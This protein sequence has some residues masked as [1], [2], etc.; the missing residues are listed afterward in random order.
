MKNKKLFYGIIFLVLILILVYGAKQ[1]SNEQNSEEIYSL[2]KDFWVT[3]KSSFL[4]LSDAGSKACYR[5]DLE[6]PAD[7]R[8]AEICFYVQYRPYW[9]MVN[10][11]TVVQPLIGG[12]QLP[13]LKNLDITSYLQ[14]GHNAITFSCEASIS[15]ESWMSAEGIIFC[16]DGTTIRITT[17]SWI[18]GWDIDGNW[19]D[20]ATIP[21]DMD[22]VIPG[23]TPLEGYPDDVYMHSYYGSIH[24]DPVAYPTEKAMSQPIFNDNTAH[25]LLKITL[26]NMQETGIDSL[27]LWAITFN[28][29][30]GKSI[31]KQIVTLSPTGSLDLAGRVDLGELP[32]GAYNVRLILYKGSVVLDRRDYEIVRVGKYELPEV[33]GTNYEDGMVLNEVYSIDCSAETSPETFVAS[34]T[35]WGEAGY[36]WKEVETEVLDGPGG[37]KYRALKDCT[38]MYYFAYKYEIENLYVPHLAVVEWPDDEIRNFIIHI[39]EPGTGSPYYND[40]NAGYQRSE[41]GYIADQDL[42]PERS[43][44]MKKMHLLF[45]PNSK[46]GS[47]FICNVGPY[48]VDRYTTNPGAAS[49]ITFYEITSDLPKLRIRDAG[50]HL[51][52][53]HTERGPYTLSSSYYSGPFGSYFMRRLAIRNHPWFY[54]NWYVTTE[55]LIKRMLFSGQNLY[56]MGHFMYQSTLYPSDMSRY[57]YSQNTYTGG[58]VIRDN[59]G[60]MLSMFNQNKISMISGVEH[61]TVDVLA[62][63]QPTPEEIRAGVDHLFMVGR[64]GNLFPYMPADIPMEGGIAVVS[65]T[66]TDQYAGRP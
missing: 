38:N 53:P 22:S 47:I 61:F 39:K 29:A 9:I 62:D 43:N 20:P 25:T 6:L 50:D 45:W 12:Q 26:L 7:A 37:K 49:K 33:E 63:N 52:G 13:G 8:K 16:D 55:N 3:W 11:D 5:K 23:A 46:Q 34:H 66:K 36:E 4:Q 57:G 59:V 40:A 15:Y 10:N 14:Q 27:I 24:V 18:G 32:K 1:V 28:E 64:D 31:S 58:D 51:I 48:E 41:A 54:H 21:L 17:D 44:E 56:M 30:S 35:N 42:H 19:T 60:L 65:P 2:E